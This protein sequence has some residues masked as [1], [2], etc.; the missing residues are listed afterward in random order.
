MKKIKIEIKNY[1]TDSVLF[2]YESK[3]NTLKKT[4]DEAVKQGAN[5]RGAN[6]RGANLR[7]A[8]NLSPLYWDNLN[9]LRMQ[10]GKLRAFKYL[11][12]DE[13]PIDDKKLTYK[14]DKTVIEK[15]YDDSDL[16]SCSKGLNVATL[17]WCLREGNIESNNFIEVEFKAS[18]I[19]AIPYN[20]DG[21]FRVKKLKVIRKIPKAELKKFLARKV[22]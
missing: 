3:D 2:E 9:I 5:L 15:D 7:G 14:V 11:N 20:S 21:K 4:L 18:D 12:G 13:S 8:K 19:V 1:F 10:K 22:R 17:E 6:L 16:V